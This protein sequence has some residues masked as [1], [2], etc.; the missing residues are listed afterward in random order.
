[1]FVCY[2]CVYSLCVFLSLVVCCLLHC[3]CH[4]LLP[5]SMSRCTFNVDPDTHIDSIEAAKQVILSG[6]WSTK[7]VITGMYNNTN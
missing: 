6:S 5:M 1:M 4:C 3:L 7:I 2:F